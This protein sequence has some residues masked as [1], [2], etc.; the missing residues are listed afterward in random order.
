MKF[1]IL[2]SD[3]HEKPT[4]APIIH[5]I[6]KLCMVAPTCFSITLP[7]SG[8]VPSAFWKFLNWGAVDRILWIGVLCLVMW[9]L[10]SDTCLW[11]RSSWR[12]ENPMAFILWNSI[13]SYTASHP[14]T[15]GPA[16][17]SLSNLQT[18]NNLF[19]CILQL[20]CYISIL[21]WLLPSQNDVSVKLDIEDKFRH[22]GCAL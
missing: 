16:A 6:Y 4:N 2:C 3:I 7:S 20:F 22:L 19:H 9:C 1:R 11:V 10:G 13:S 17:T 5:S 18:L 8:S 14:R 21:S 12:I 15:R